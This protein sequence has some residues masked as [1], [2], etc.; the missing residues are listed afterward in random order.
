MTEISRQ[1]KVGEE[2]LFSPNFRFC[3]K[4]GWGIVKN[5]S[6][7]FRSSDDIQRVKTSFK[8]SV[9]DQLGNPTV[10]EPTELCVDVEQLWDEG[11][12]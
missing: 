10:N 2:C 12:T 5:S 9:V 11:F 4:G 6:D 3:L 1:H 8:F 7:V